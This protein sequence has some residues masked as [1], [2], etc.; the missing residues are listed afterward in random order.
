MIV[1][2]WVIS[3]FLSTLS[4]L[5]TSNTAQPKLLKLTITSLLRRKRHWLVRRMSVAL[6]RVT[7]TMPYSR[8]KKELVGLAVNENG[9]F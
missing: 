3:I 8:K 5:K 1:V 7:L 9:I 6:V 2:L 4:I